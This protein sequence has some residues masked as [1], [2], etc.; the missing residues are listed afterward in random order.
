MH[1]TRMKT[2]H[3]LYPLSCCTSN[4]PLNNITIQNPHI[5]FQASKRK[6]KLKKLQRNSQPASQP[7]RQTD[8]HIKI[9]ILDPKDSL[10]EVSC[11]IYSF[12]PMVI[13][14]L[15]S[16]QDILTSSLHLRLKLSIGFYFKFTS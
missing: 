8:R 6:E 13:C 7:D 12:R 5:S 14:V 10:L 11:P 15:V 4:A 1:L 2:F 16:C 9:Q 3:Q